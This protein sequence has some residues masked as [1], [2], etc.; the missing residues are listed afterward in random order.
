MNL[1]ALL[2]VLAI[3]AVAFAGC[4]GKGGGESGDQTSSSSSSSG[5]ATSSATSTSTSSMSTST[6]QNQTGNAT[7]HPPTA[8][9]IA[10]PTNGSAPLNVSFNLTGSDPDGHAI[11]W[12]LN[13]GDNAT[14]NGTLLPANVTHNYTAAGNY[15]TRF[16]VRDSANATV[17]V[18]VNITVT[19]GGSGGGGGP[20]SLN[21]AVTT[22]CPL[23]QEEGSGVS[24]SLRANHKGDDATWFTLPATY[25]GRPFATT[26]TE[27]LD[28]DVEFLATCTAG[29]ASLGFFHGVDVHEKGVVPAGAGCAVLWTWYPGPSTLTLAIL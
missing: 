9:V 11:N 10:A 14:L 17:N 5:S 2:T 6:G 7:N 27:D 1:Q 3:V 26:E 21:G 29:A 23:C 19:A 13:L 16:T 8:T 15:S 20:V 25:A 24:V 12:I 28:S 22:S 18:T 4:S